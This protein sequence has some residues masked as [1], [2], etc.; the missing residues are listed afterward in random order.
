MSEKI[1]NSFQRVLSGK[2]EKGDWL[3]LIILFG[4]FG[5]IFGLSWWKGGSVGGFTFIL[6]VATIWNIR[7][8]QGLLKQSK[9]A[10]KQAK[11]ALESSIFREIV[12]STLQLNAIL[13]NDWYFRKKEKRTPYI[14]NSVAGM[15]IALKNIDR[16]MFEK[17][18]EAIET[19]NE[20]DERTPATIFLEALDMVKKGI[21]V[22]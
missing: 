13:R 18:S 9:E 4:L 21:S 16:D 20:T 6:A 3:I 15:L 10:S 12:S 22:E 17:I 7:I 19:W 14:K 8:T 5:S 2:M 1:V 11:R